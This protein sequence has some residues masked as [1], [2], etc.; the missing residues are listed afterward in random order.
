MIPK[1]TE[2]TARDLIVR[3]ITG[4]DNR[5][6]KAGDQSGHLI[7]TAM[8]TVVRNDHQEQSVGEKKA[9]PGRNL[10]GI[11]TDNPQA[12]QV[13]KKMLPLPGRR[14]AA[15]ISRIAVLARGHIRKSPMGAIAVSC[16][17]VEVNDHGSVPQNQERP[18]HLL[19]KT[20]EQQG[21]I[22]TSLMPVS[23]HAAK[24]MI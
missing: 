22:N 5:I 17:T 6:Q 13:T 20:T 7:E 18:R 3:R 2:K 4:M 19:P 9:R 12:G 24:P 8:H 15:K 11:N 16:Q 14:K 1:I 21:L 23:A 10:K